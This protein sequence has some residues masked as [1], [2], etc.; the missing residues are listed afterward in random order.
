M[1][2]LIVEL[3]CH[4]LAVHLTHAEN[5]SEALR[6]VRKDENRFHLDIWAG[7]GLSRI[8]AREKMAT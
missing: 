6:Q 7:G 5:E 8:K 4:K 3:A 2:V 1:A